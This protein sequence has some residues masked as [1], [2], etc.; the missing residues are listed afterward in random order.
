MEL[1]DKIDLYLSSCLTGKG[2]MSDEI[3]DKLGD[4]VKETMRSQ[5]N[6]G[7]REFKMSMSS[8]G[9]PLCMQQMQKAGA[10]RELDPPNLKTKFAYGYLTEALVMAIMEAAGINVEEFQT[11]VEV[12]L[13]NVPIHGTLDV[14]IDGKVWDIKSVTATAFKGIYSRGDGFKKLVKDD[15]FGYISQ[16]YLYGRGRGLPFGG[17]I[18][19]NKESGEIA[20]MAAPHN[21][22]KFEEAA[23]KEAEDNV[24]ALMSDKP[25]KRCYEP[26]DD[27]AYKKTT[28]NKI[29]HV[30]CSYCPYKHTCWGD[31]IE[32]KRRGSVILS[33][34]EKKYISGKKWMFV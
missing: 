16:G 29:L 26:V 4:R 21:G 33:N 6:N 32:F 27:K 19:L 9:R 25:F 8:I 28:G 30:R 24:A 18:A 5:F 7:E 3:L 22:K 2:A 31:Q 20:V 17:W 11:E 13:A 1:Q 10:E 23:I 12:V 15:P 34:G 14:V